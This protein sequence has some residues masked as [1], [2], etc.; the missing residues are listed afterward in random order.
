MLPIVWKPGARSAHSCKQF[1]RNS[2][3][4]SKG[5]Y[6]CAH[7]TID[8]GD[9][10]CRGERDTFDDMVMIAEDGSDVTCLHVPHAH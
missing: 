5:P 10:C 2:Q 8:G 3:R 9:C 4:R 1:P 7:E 6:L